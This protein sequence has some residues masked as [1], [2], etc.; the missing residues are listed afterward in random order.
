MGTRYDF[1]AVY[2][3]A[4]LFLVNLP[5]SI[6]ATTAWQPTTTL[7]L[8][9][10]ASPGS[11][12]D[13]LARA[14]M[15]IMDVHKLVPTALIVSNRQGGG[16]TLA[17]SHLR[18]NQGNPHYLS[19]ATGTL[20]TNNIT[21][22]TKV[23][24]VDFT[25]LALLFSDYNVFSVRVDS[26]IHDGREL[27]NRLRASP[28]SLSFAF[29]AAPGNY[30]HIA[31]ARVAKAANADLKQ[32]RAVV[33]DGGGKAAAAL[34]GGHVDVL[35]GGPG[36]IVGHV[37]AGR[38]R[39]IAVSAPQRY[40]EKALADV[41]TW[42][43]QGLNNIADNPYYFLGPQGLQQ[44]QIDYWEQVFAKVIKTEEWREFARKGFWTTLGMSRTEAGAYLQSQYDDYRETL[45]EVGLAQ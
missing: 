41:A 29:A 11:V 6:A 15:Q 20:I 43:E 35:V 22:L 16:G 44:S 24:Y 37:Q 34:L 12:H 38:L 9:A 1:M 7:E 17:L 2:F 14:T 19:T 39:A 4:A 13:R 26:P 40:E 31:I 42:K 45:R 25:L 23:R 30:N 5:Q 36:N 32:I 3:V 10:A 28:T 33:F 21:G 18:Q 27:L 8:I